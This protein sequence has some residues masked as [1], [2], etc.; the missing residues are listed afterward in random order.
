[1]PIARAPEPKGHNSDYFFKMAG[2]KCLRG[3][4][5]HAMYLLKRGLV[6][7][8]DHYLCRFN[9]GVVQFKFGLIAEAAEDFLQLTNKYENEPWPFHNLA[10]CLI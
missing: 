8:P 1:M 4:F 7:N 3:E 2:K 6:Q 5:P 10:I 9:H